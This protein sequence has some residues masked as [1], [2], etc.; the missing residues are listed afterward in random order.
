[1]PDPRLKALTTIPNVGPAV[2]RRLLR[3]GIEAPE[4]LRGRDPDELFQRICALEGR[5]EDVCLL[6]TFRAAVAF[7]DGEPE[8]PWWHY[9]RE[10][11]AAAASAAASGGPACIRPDKVT[12]R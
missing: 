7:A 5:R 6:D 11:L 1:M 2:A 3:L 9:S 8:R 12:T 4:D 10:R